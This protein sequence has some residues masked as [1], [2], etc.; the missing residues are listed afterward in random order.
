MGLHD[1]TWYTGL[2]GGFRLS[3]TDCDFDAKLIYQEING[4]KAYLITTVVEIGYM[5][6]QLS[7]S[8]T[9]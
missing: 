8:A 2:A 6:L 7:C 4:E 1:W 9:G 5:K 3:A